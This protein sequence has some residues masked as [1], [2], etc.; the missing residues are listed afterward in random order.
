[1]P[2]AIRRKASIYGGR[3]PLDLPTYTLGEIAHCL[4][5][6]YATT[7]AWVLGRK[8]PSAS[9]DKWAEP[10][11]EVADKDTPALSFRNVVELHVLS[12]IRRK[13]QVSM[14]AIRSAIDYLRESLDLQRP[15]ADQQMLTD[16]RDLFIRHLG[17]L[18]NISQRGQL[19]MNQVVRAY[20]LRIERSP[21]GVPIQLFP[22]TGS[23]IQVAPKLVVMNPR[24]QFG[25]PCIV[26]T[27]I[28]T[29]IIAERYKA[30]DSIKQL[31]NDYG[32]AAKK[33]EEAIRYELETAA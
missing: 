23:N 14:P 2:G 11:I 4:Q 16:G 12:A 3:D 21:A 19:E 6:P 13:H 29:A 18:V 1:M 5:V 22:F 24:V 28:P 15:L 17:N 27:G 32:Q 9:G 20:L 7:R 25:R 31:V 10:L 30:G 26:G 8:Y 33:I